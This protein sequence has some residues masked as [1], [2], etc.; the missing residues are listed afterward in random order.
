[1]T[2]IFWYDYETTGINPRCDRAVQVAGIRTDLE[3][4]RALGR[5]LLGDISGARLMR[6]KAAPPPMLDWLR[7]PAPQSAVDDY[8][9]WQRQVLTASFGERRFMKL[10]LSADDLYSPSK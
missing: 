7:L 10:D 6:E 1:M 4:I 5:E 2:S 3:L 9:T 8:H